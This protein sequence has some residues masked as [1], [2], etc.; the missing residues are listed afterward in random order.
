MINKATIERLLD[1]MDYTESLRIDYSGFEGH[2][3]NGVSSKSIYIKD[4][5]NNDDCLVNSYGGSTKYRL[6]LIDLELD[7]EFICAKFNLYSKNEYQ[8]EFSFTRGY[9]MIIPYESITS[10]CISAINK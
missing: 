7:D 9:T 8:T 4:I 1:N 10:M 2:G 3:I 6:N 5:E